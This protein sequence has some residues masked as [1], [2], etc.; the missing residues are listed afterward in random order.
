[1]PF[2]Q[3]NTIFGITMCMTSDLNLE[4]EAFANRQQRQHTQ[5]WRGCFPVVEAL[6]GH[7]GLL[8]QQYIT[9]TTAAL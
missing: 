7:I 5:D 8:F 9:L 2:H 4:N 3:K 6:T 1:M